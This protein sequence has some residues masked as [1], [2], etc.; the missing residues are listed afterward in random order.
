ML[1]PQS[2]LDDP[3]L[4]HLDSSSVS[5]RKPCYAGGRVAAIVPLRRDPLNAT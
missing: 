4:F 2:H 1:D 5:C 3:G